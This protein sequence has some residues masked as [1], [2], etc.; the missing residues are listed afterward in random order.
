MAV[1]Q[2]QMSWLI[3]RYRGQ[4]PSHIFNPINPMNSMNSMNPINPR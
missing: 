3:H 4:A 1:G 2:L